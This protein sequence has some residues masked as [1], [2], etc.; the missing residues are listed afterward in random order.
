MLYSMT[1]NVRCGV[2]NNLAD[3]NGLSDKHRHEEGNYHGCDPLLACFILEGDAIEND[4][5]DRP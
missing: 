2:S 5:D 1:S 4:H 3:L